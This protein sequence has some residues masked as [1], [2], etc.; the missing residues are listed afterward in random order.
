MKKGMELQFHWIFVLIAGILILVFFISL[1]QKHRTASEKKL[2]ASLSW[3]LD[4]AFTA[5]MKSPQTAQVHPAPP[6]G[7]EFVCD[8]SCQIV[9]GRV[10]K[11]FGDRPIFASGYAT[12]SLVL[13]TAPFE[14]PYKVA[15]ALLV[16]STG[17]T[18]YIVHEQTGESLKTY[19]Q[20][21]KSPAM[22][23][24]NAIPVRPSDIPGIEYAGSE[25]IRFVFLETEERQLPPDFDEYEVS[26][27]SIQ[28]GRAVYFNKR[29]GEED[30]TGMGSVNLPESEAAIHAAFVSR[31]SRMLNSGLQQLYAGLY[32]VSTIYE[33]RLQI[34]QQHATEE[35]LPCNYGPSITR[36]ENIKEASQ[37]LQAGLTALGQLEDPVRVLIEENE[38]LLKKGCPTVM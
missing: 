35:D 26:G 22:K 3:T 16:S 21:N 13:W 23:Y 30:W 29:A 38:N 17:M 14:M 20:L 8:P 6:G 5:V 28:S 4:T 27:V 9:I 32:R 18:Y 31:D 37:K 10:T 1:A 34:L 24:L 15:N 12:G 36:I 11:P 25:N 2:S 7:V 19:K 33:K